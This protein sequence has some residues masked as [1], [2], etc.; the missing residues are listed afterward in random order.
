MGD[1]ASWWAK[2]LGQPVAPPPS[3][4]NTWNTPQVGQPTPSYQAPPS[5]LPIQQYEGAP[6]VNATGQLHVLD[7]A[8]RWKGSRE[9]QR[10]QQLCPNCSTPSRPVYLF[11]RAISQNESGSGMVRM[12][13]INSNTGQTCEP[14]HSC[15]ECG[16][17]GLFT[18]LRRCLH[19]KGTNI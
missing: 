4:P 11:S 8:A 5:N 18:A 13:K 9:A 19:L 3:T 17:N 14:A 1:S 10:E 12:T 7:A 6:E 16:Y 15:F 2:K